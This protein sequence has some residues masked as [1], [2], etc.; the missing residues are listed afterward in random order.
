MKI[1][2]FGGSFDPVHLEHIEVAKAAISSLSL[3]KL[4]VM[5]AHVPPHKQDKILSQET[6]RLEMCK[7]AF[8]GIEKVEVSDYEIKKGGNSYTYLTCQAL[9]EIYSKDE[10]FFV[11]GTD[12][13]R[14]FPTWK[15]PEKILECAT[16]AVCA[17]NENEGW[18]EKEKRDF[19]D[20]FHCD[21]ALVHYNGK[22][23]SSTIIRVFGAAGLDLTDFVGKKVNEYIK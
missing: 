8:S 5:P 13:L 23:V 12:M 9:K 19:N 10:L 1:G 4:I 15:H 14:D 20:R 2:V 22:P 16:L 18:A 6:D 11:V 17:R 3:D 7:I 21:F